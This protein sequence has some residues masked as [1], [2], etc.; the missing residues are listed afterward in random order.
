MGYLMLI[1]I[2]EGLEIAL[3]LWMSRD[4]VRCYRSQGFQSLDSNDAEVQPIPD[5]A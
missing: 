3:G 2:V 1:G 4:E 5:F